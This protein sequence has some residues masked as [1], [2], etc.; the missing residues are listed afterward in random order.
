MG[1]ERTESAE[2]DQLLDEP[3]SRIEEMVG[4][5]PVER[6]DRMLRRLDQLDAELTHFID[7]GMVL[8]TSPNL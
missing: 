8:S 2:F 6:C 4:D 7:V 1:N 3:F 5:G